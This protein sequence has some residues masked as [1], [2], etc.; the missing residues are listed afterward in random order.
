M[1]NKITKK[2][3]FEAIIAMVEA[4]SFD[5]TAVNPDIT[6]DMA[7]EWATN[8]IGLLDKKAEKAKAYAS[9]KAAATDDLVEVIK[10]CLTTDY[11][12]I[13]DITAKAE[14]INTDITSSKVTY[15]LSK[16]VEAG[17]VTKKEV[18]VDGAE[19]KTRKL[20]GYAIA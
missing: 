16:L 3:Y 19:G 2:N 15:R 4:G 7:M 10:S 5:I 6:P 11:Q 1:E 14:A 8:E 17:V 12:T 9:K 13:S 20:Q 18:V